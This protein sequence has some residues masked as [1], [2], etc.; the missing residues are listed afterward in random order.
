MLH[1]TFH[2][3]SLFAIFTSYF[4]RW[5]IHFDWW[6]HRRFLFE[7]SVSSEKENIYINI[8]THSIQ[9]LWIQLSCEVVRI[10][11][12]FT[13]PKLIMAKTKYFTLV[14]PFESKWHYLF[15]SL[16]KCDI[17]SKGMFKNYFLI[18]GVFLDPLQ[19]PV[20]ISFTDHLVI[21]PEFHG[22]LNFHII[23]RCLLILNDSQ[24][25]TILSYNAHSCLKR[26][27]RRQW[28]PEVNFSICS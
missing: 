25:I 14:T 9:N 11:L 22:P 24:I 26:T 28:N 2:G 19:S 20:Q 21:K 27:L 6:V 18:L 23:Y 4:N 12:W 5:C 10:S 1:N 16:A 15:N 7:S 8:Y 13:L 17:Y 3:I